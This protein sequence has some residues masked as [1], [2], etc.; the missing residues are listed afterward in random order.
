M[1]EFREL[2]RLKR[3]FRE[4]IKDR[5]REGGR[6]NIRGREER[7][8]WNELNKTKYRLQRTGISHNNNNNTN[9]A[10]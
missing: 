7:R 1:S 3:K 4:A 6:C 10:A 9:D 2:R 5:K 8:K